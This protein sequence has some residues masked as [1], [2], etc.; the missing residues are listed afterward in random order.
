MVE[1]GS[2]GKFM[3]MLATATKTGICRAAIGHKQPSTRASRVD[4]KLTPDAMHC[5][6]VAQR[7]ATVLARFAPRVG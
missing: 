7:V 5:T 3:F 1:R 4:R 6:F 2:S